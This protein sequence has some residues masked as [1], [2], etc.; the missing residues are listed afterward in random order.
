MCLPLV[1]LLSFDASVV[2]VLSDISNE[3]GKALRA[4]Y[5]ALIVKE[6]VNSQ[7][8]IN[9]V[10][11]FLIGASFLLKKK[12]FLSCIAQITPTPPEHDNCNFGIFDDYGDKN[13]PKS[14]NIT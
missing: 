5:R 13:L 12:H 11:M 7:T 4:S 6:E 14:K 8:T 3:D 10:Q 2:I 9:I 1:H